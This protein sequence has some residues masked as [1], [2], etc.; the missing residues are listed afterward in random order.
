MV[1]GNLRIFLGAAPGAGKTFAMLEEGQRLRLQGAHVVV[2]ALSSKA[3]RETLALAEGLERCPL[4]EGK[5]DE[6]DLDVEAVLA[7]EPGVVLVDDYA[8]RSGSGVPRWEGVAVLL[9][10]G[11]DVISTLDIRNLESVSDVVLS[12]TGAREPET[13]PDTAVRGANQ[14]ELVD[15]SPELLRQR[16]GEGKIYASQEEADRALAGDFRT[17]TLTALRELALLWLAE[18]IDAGLS[19]YRAQHNIRDSWQTREKIVIGLSGQA[20]GQALIRRAARMLAGVPGGELHAVHVRTGTDANE[21]FS[22]KE[23]ELQRKLTQDVGGFFHVVGG[24]DTAET[25]TDFARNINASQIILGTSEQRSLA[26]LGRGTVDKVRRNAGDIDVHLVAHNAGTGTSPRRGRS[27]LGRRREIPAFVLAVGLPPL[28][29]LVLDVLPHQQL[30]TDM[31][32]QLTGIVAVALVGGLWPAVAAAFLAGLIVNYFSVRP[33]GSLSVLDPENVLALLIFLLVAV[34]VSLV[35]DR[36]ARRSKE[37]HLAGAEASVLGELSRRAV[38]EGSSIPAFLEH[39]REH[40]Q[41]AGAGLW[42]RSEGGPRTPRVWSLQEYSGTSRPDALTEADSV[43]PLDEDR[44][45]SL[46]GRE[47]SQ[48]ER[49]LLAAFGSHLLALLQR[50][51]LNASQ[52]ENLRLA[53]GNKMRTSILRAVSHDLRTPLA[54]I[55]LA[56][57]SLRDKTITLT[58]EDQEELL[59]TIE[60]GADRLDGLVSN[61]LDMSRITADSVSPL[62]TPV[63]WADAVGEALRSTTS[64]RLRVLLPD[65]MPP[66]DADPGMLERVIAN[67]VEN[68]LKYAPDSDVV[69]AGSVGGSG[70]ARIGQR[71]ASE[72]TVVDHGAGIPAEEVLAMFR[73]FQRAGDTTP[74]TGIGLGLAV[75]KGFTEAMGG[76][77]LAEPT[78][79]GGL[80][81]VVRLP[82]STGVPPAMSPEGRHAG[83][84][85]SR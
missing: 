80:T 1:G 58:K 3:R 65:N 60:S 29:Q 36:S 17:G 75:A 50:E 26:S 12:I 84:T 72:L 82:L 62:I 53:E 24:E 15:A 11:I 14:I 54:G 32:V 5:A 57:S 7:R 8:R 51:E 33:V 27:R 64:E 61:L 67:L 10:A 44:I 49:R 30:S 41:A 77:L 70:S 18:R 39:V 43:E 46:T 85:D 81:M 31:L 69:V 35:V 56:A 20:E 38:A 83:S 37:A 21:M 74:G 66:V 71:P 42:T 76:V 55:K 19:D 13:V 23:L 73:P 4:P 59:A 22:G 6:A 25:L 52:R 16:L 48:D 45:L 40:F 79:G 47:L 63:Y 2:G 9:D 78:P 34:A 28:L 68:A